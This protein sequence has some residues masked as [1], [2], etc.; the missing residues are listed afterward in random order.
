MYICDLFI[1]IFSL[2]GG[3][4][5]KITVASSKITVALMRHKISS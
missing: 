3:Y 4:S 2:I 1:Y 5:S